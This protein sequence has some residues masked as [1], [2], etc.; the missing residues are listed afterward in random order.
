MNSFSSMMPWVKRSGRIK[1][2]ATG[3]F[4]SHPK[5][6]QEA[7]IIL[8][9]SL[10]PAHTSIHS[11]PIVSKTLSFNSFTLIFSILSV[12][13]FLISNYH[14]I[15]TAVFWLQNAAH[16]NCKDTRIIWKSECFFKKIASLYWGLCL[17]NTFLCHKKAELNTI[18]EVGNR[19]WFTL[20]L[21]RQL[22]K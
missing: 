15:A 12:P 13:F 6:P 14:K 22:K 20:A 11:L 8:K 10:L 4:Q 18:C 7:V 16:I 2:T 19:P 21:H 3:L 17:I 1:T 9:W 5:Q